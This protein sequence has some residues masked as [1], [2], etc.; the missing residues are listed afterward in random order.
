MGLFINTNVASLNAQR[1][2]L[3]S[4]NRLAKNFQRLSSG[5]RINT[6]GDDAAGLAIAE[7]F[8]SQVR[9]LSQ[10]IR[11]AND[12][13]SLAQVAEGA[14]Q[15][16]TQILQRMRELAVQSANDINTDRD[17]EA[18]DEEVDQ[19]IEELT[20]IGENT[21]FNS[22]KLLDG[23]FI[24]A[25]FHVGAFAQE[26]VRVRIRDARSETLGRWATET[27]LAVTTDPI[28]PGD[29]VLNGVTVRSTLPDDDTVSTSFA[30]GSAIAKAEAINDGT[31]Y[32]GVTAKPLP[33]VLT[34]GAGILGGTLDNTNNITINGQ[35]ITGVVVNRDDAQDKLVRAINEVFDR[36][37]VFASLNEDNQ[38]VLRA[39]D[40]RNIE[41]VTQG[42]AAARLGIGT[43]VQTA[44]LN[45]SSEEQYLVEGA[46]EAYVGFG[47]D[48]LV[49][50]NQNES[51]VTVD[52]RSRQA[53]NDSI[54]KLDRAIDQITSDRAELGAVVNRIERTISNLSNIVEN[55]SA[56]RSRIQD[57]D[58]ALETSKLTKNNILQQAAIGILAQANNSPQQVLQLLQQ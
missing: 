21:T 20:R 1:N 28:T 36:T 34:G 58:F 25:F 26:T 53:A 18:L 45:L 44:Q 8:T 16:T 37:G 32:H 11:N 14:L 41:V 5:L 17:R 49:G 13:T 57:A 27:G 9:G 33:N 15:E 35:V 43:Q 54:I 39:E 4:Q 42:N 29:L 3:H 2:L 10:A 40:G 51:V 38:L 52:I 12:A 23:S 24:D 56:A 47:V 31:E 22:K 46:N 48:Q 30:T 6:A 50:V 7:R 19:L 55:S